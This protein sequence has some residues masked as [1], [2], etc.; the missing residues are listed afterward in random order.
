MT[1]LSICNS[2][3]SALFYGAILRQYFSLMKEEVPELEKE[4]TD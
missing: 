1:Q 2:L 3:F 4:I